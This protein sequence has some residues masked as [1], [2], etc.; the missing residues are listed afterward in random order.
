MWNMRMGGVGEGVPEVTQ[1]RH[2][3]NRSHAGMYALGVQRVTLGG[4]L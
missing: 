1:P 3:K 2:A 4:I